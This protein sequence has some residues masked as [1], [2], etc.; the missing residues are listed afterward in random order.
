MKGMHSIDYRDYFFRLANGTLIHGE[1]VNDP[2]L[3]DPET[4]LEFDQMRGILSGRRKSFF[5]DKM[6]SNQSDQISSGYCS[7][8]EDEK[9]KETILN[10]IYFNKNDESLWID[11]ILPDLYFIDNNI[12]NDF[13]PFNK[14]YGGDY[15]SYYFVN[16]KISDKRLISKQNQLKKESNKS[17]KSIKIDKNV[18][19]NILL[20]LNGLICITVDITQ[21][22]KKFQKQLKNIWDNYCNQNTKNIKNFKNYNDFDVNKY[23]INKENEMKCF[24]IDKK[25]DKVYYDTYLPLNGADV[26]KYG[27][28]KLIINKSVYHRMSFRDYKW[29]FEKIFPFLNKINVVVC[30]CKSW[31]NA[32]K[33]YIKSQI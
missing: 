19:C 4:K 21:Y 24:N 22:Y 6:F 25:N 11:V 32:A 9:I 3:T 2:N 15:Q 33:K 12:S 26:S 29:F 28:G 16:G 23:F 1:A 8:E 13:E 17:N 10:K 7:K 31:K 27:N 14:I 18:L 5:W 20:R 30:V